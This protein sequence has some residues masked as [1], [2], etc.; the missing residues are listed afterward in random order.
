MAPPRRST[1]STNPIL[2][3]KCNGLSRLTAIVLC[4]QEDIALGNLNKVMNHTSTKK[5]TK[6]LNANKKRDHQEINLTSATSKD[7]ANNNNE[8]MTTRDEKIVATSASMKESGNSGA[9][10]KE[11]GDEGDKEQMTV[12]TALYPYHIHCY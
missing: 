2:S 7:D 1:R 9:S 10:T 6:A 8:G 3:D 4:L 11:G 12:D 5:E